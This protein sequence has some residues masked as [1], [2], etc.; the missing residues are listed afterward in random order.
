MM[1]IK[2]KN[3]FA[4]LML[5]LILFSISN[6][7]NMNNYN[8]TVQEDLII[9][10]FNLKS[11]GFWNNFTFI[12]VT[13]LN[14]TIANE[15]DWCSGSGTWGN[16]YIIENMIINAS[17]SPIGCGIFIENSVDVYFTIRNVT[18]FETAN[19]I[20]LENTNKGVLINNRLLDNIDSGISLVNCVNNTI[21]R[22]Q[23][24]NNGGQGI[25]LFSNCN[26]N[27]ILENTA[28]ND[29]TNFQDTGIYLGDYC[30]NNEIMGNVVSDNNV[31]GIFIEDFC[32]G[33]LIYNNTLKNVVGNQQDYGIRIYNNCDQNN[34]SLNVIE[35]LNNFG[36]YVVTS[37]ETSISNNQIIDISTG[38]YMLI[39][40][41][42]DIISNTISGG[43]AGIL[44]SACSGGNI[45]GNF[46]NNTTN[47]GIR[48]YTNC[49]DNEFH[50][51]I[52]KDNDGIGIQ[53]YEP[54]NDNNLFYRNSFI[55][56][57]VH[58]FDNGTA[59]FWN[60]TVI[61]NYWDNYS[62]LDLN[63]DH[64]GDTPLFIPGGAIS[65]DSLPIFDDRA[66]IINIITPTSSGYGAN[67]P[68]FNINVNETYVYSL[69][70]TINNG[71]IKYY[72]TENGTIDQGAWNALTEGNVLF[73]FYARDIAWN[74]DFESVIVIKDTVNPIVSIT[75]PTGGE[76]FGT[77]APDYVL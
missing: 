36:I 45:I 47:Y 21:S 1:K 71:G 73:T 5:F 56:N 2:M 55:S 75:S 38:M 54:L 61:G 4:F 48:M 59:N 22:N 63:N 33:N 69:W 70:Y 20:K 32:E 40:Q 31:N 15:T 62:G 26:N 17:G 34:V 41:L 65:S 35:N 74:L 24:I 66:P 11:S 37:D 50:D 19:G 43:S 72:F 76:S 39:A 67:A 12:H 8:E 16:P 14:W 53:L 46:I 28:K 52:I 64:I 25:N 23:L 30:D 27:K 68:E 3:I 58:V 7:N 57:V 49:D 13:N 29:G 44:M 42:S 6:L 9:R 10:K 51:N 77:T 18:I 60:N